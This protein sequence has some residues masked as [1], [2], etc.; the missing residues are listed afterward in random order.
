[1]QETLEKA[2][3]LAPKVREISDEVLKE[4]VQR[5]EMVAAT[6][7]AIVA[8]RPAFFLGTPG[9]D[10]TGTVKTMMHRIAG[11]VYHDELMPTIA[12]GA[13]LLVESTSLREI[14]EADGGKSIMTVDKVGR[15]ANAH[16]F[17]ADEVWKT[18]EGALKVL[19][20]LFNLDDIRWEGQRVRNNLMTFLAASNELP[21]P[22]G[23]L[24]ALWSRMTIRV[25]VNPLDR[26]GKKALVASRLKRY[27][28]AANG[29]ATS[30]AAKLSLAD[31]ELLRKA[32]PFVEVSND[33]VEIVLDIL[34]ELVEDTTQDF[35]W[36][37]ADD[38]RFGR[39][40]DVMQANALLNGRTKVTKA[41]LAILEWLL[42]DTPEQI[43]V[44]K[45]KIAPYTRTA[46]TEAQELVDSLL[47][48][49]G[50]IQLVTTGN[51]AKGVEAL[52]QCESTEA[53][54]KRLQDEAS[55][56]TMRQTIAALANQ[57][58]M[59]KND[60]IGIVTGTK[61]PQGGS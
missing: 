39:I 7:L 33:I 34:Q 15:A 1:M 6:W 44:V 10:K 22:E 12:S 16:I 26:G 57:V 28:G 41:D 49:G 9:V 54:L 43:T 59:A 17:F 23:K 51:R 42:W 60:V 32:R 58:E 13:Q 30:P 61:K 11:A 55:D 25:V 36:A 40:F 48:P 29:T 52:T 47:A 5:Q 38:R 24:Y 18:E 50:T 31:V 8:G 20:D 3:A 46:L 53:E 21:D 35:K 19:F 37:W 2:I 4:H 45:A 27:R 56:D 14:P